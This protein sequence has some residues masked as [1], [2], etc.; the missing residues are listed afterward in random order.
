M[1]CQEAVNWILESAKLNN[2]VFTDDVPD[3]I[4]MVDAPDMRDALGAV[5]LGSMICKM[6]DMDPTKNN[7][8]KIHL[9]YLEAKG[10]KGLSRK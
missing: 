6:L 10:I 8:I 7:Y 4:K 2:G 3:I 1:T 5:V 9:D